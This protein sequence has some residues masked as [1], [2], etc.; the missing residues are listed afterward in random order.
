MNARHPMT[1]A[2]KG[3]H[4]IS[5]KPTPQQRISINLSIAASIAHKRRQAKGE[6]MSRSGGPWAMAIHAWAV[7][8][9]VDGL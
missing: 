3:E 5:A 8:G 2:W 7:Q 9:K 6:N 1:D 4:L